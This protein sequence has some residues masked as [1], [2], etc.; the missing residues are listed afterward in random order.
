M[1]PLDNNTA[2]EAGA[3]GNNNNINN[4]SPFVFGNNS[5]TNNGTPPQS[6]LNNTSTS[7]S[8][9]TR[10]APQSVME[11]L[12]NAPERQREALHNARHNNP[13]IDRSMP[14]AV[15]EAM[16]WDA[17]R[18]RSIDSGDGS[19]GGGGGEEGGSNPFYRSNPS[20]HSILSAAERSIRVMMHGAPSSSNNNNNSSD[21]SNIT[22]ITGSA[23]S[24]AEILRNINEAHRQVTLMQQNGML[25][26]TPRRLVDD[27]DDSSDS[28]S[29]LPSLLDPDDLPPLYD[30]NDSVTAAIARAGLAA[31]LGTSPNSSSNNNN[32]NAQEQDEWIV[33][34]DAAIRRATTELQERRALPG[35]RTRTD[36]TNHIIPPSNNNNIPN[37]D[38][39]REARA[40]IHR[41]RERV[42]RT[43]T[44]SELTD[45]I[46]TNRGEIGDNHIDEDEIARIHVAL[47]EES[48]SQADDESLPALENLPHLPESLSLRQSAIPPLI[49]AARTTESTGTGT[50]DTR[51][52]GMRRIMNRLMFHTMRQ[53]GLL[54]PGLENEE[55]IVDE[56]GQLRDVVDL[57]SMFGGE[58]L[59][60]V[61]PTVDVRKLDQLVCPTCMKVHLP[62]DGTE[63]ISLPKEEGAANVDISLE[64]GAMPIDENDRDNQ[65]ASYRTAQVENDS[66][67][68]SMPPLD[69]DS[70]HLSMDDDDDD[71]MYPGFQ[72][73]LAAMMSS[74][75][76]REMPERN[77]DSDAARRAGARIAERLRRHENR[78]RENSDSDD[79][80]SMP[81]LETVQGEG[82]ANNLEDEAGADNDVDGA[83]SA[84]DAS[85]APFLHPRNDA[86]GETSNG[87]GASIEEAVPSNIEVSATDG[88][89]EDDEVLSVQN[90]VEPHDEDMP[91]LEDIPG[92]AQESNDGTN[93]R[94][95]DADAAEDDSLSVPPLVQ[96]SESESSD[97]DSMPPLI[98]RDRSSSSS[99]SDSSLPALIP[100]NPSMRLHAENLGGPLRVG[101][102][103]GRLLGGGGIGGPPGLPTGGTRNRS[104]NTADMNNSNP[105]THLRDYGALR[106]YARAT[107]PICLDEHEPI[108]ALPCGHCVCDLD[109]K[110]L[111]GYLACDKAK[112]MEEVAATE[113]EVDDEPNIGAPPRPP[114]RTGRRRGTAYVHSVNMNCQ[115]PN[116]NIESHGIHRSLYS[117]NEVEH[118]GIRLEKCYPI[119]AKIISDGHGGLW[120]HE[121]QRLGDSINWPLLHRNKHGRETKR[122]EMP[123]NCD[124]EPDGNGGVWAISRP[125]QELNNN[126]ISEVTRYVVGN[127][128]EAIVQHM[129]Y[130][131][132]GSDTY[133]AGGRGGKCWVYVAADDDYE[134]TQE[135]EDT[136]LDEGLWLIGSN[137][138]ER[139]DDVNDGVGL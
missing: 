45:D 48:N 83:N 74:A 132:Q 111:G 49:P 61:N 44:L 86:N 40:A 101:T 137:T 54:P 55:D 7:T 6:V 41:L 62:V 109:Y 24:S 43:P 15:R 39:D 53:R 80:S 96:R 19:G 64:E 21:N 52:P 76:L 5:N 112:L 106:V 35:A 36:A 77:R 130:C 126:H 89:H 26:E 50:D 117:L 119:A 85:T 113:G 131:P 138:C 12:V 120:I 97:L 17:N 8:T 91:P 82:E 58:A 69:S 67:E 90:E 124:L 23:A 34:V 107:C 93:H 14:P 37:D 135:Q 4:T 68:S 105:I 104:S 10:A 2:G 114:R 56:N 95:E 99:S 116:C 100:G 28:N 70:E 125:E 134:F 42:G 136:M 115:N 110:Q 84:Y 133:Y 9:S 63:R 3:N 75:S 123:R 139:L 108:V 128:G 33:G 20:A 38:I 30:N 32:N 57:L 65:S 122:F 25:R 98:Q 87:G 79:D 29:S 51:L 94:N 88:Q 59:F 71:D 102:G 78:A 121:G 73:D 27:D 103:F 46:V 60:D 118:G 1:A 31:T 66:V 81:S 11:R 72:A 127:D 16:R 92:A 18:S 22:N 47:V 13:L 129:A